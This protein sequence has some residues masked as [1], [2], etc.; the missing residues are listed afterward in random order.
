MLEQMWEASDIHLYCFPSL[1]LANSK[2]D[3]RSEE[4]DMRTKAYILDDKMHSSCMTSV[5]R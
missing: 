5:S 1:L 3:G 4:Q 2:D